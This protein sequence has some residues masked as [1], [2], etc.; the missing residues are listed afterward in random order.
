[1][2]WCHKSKKGIMVY[3]ARDLVYLSST[4]LFLGV[5]ISF[6]EGAEI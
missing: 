3:P 4:A 5:V 1:M 2:L 6:L